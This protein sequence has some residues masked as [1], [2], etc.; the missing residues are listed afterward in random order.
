MSP[1]RQGRASPERK[2]SL[3]SILYYTCNW[4]VNTRNVPKTAD[5]IV[6]LPVISNLKVDVVNVSFAANTPIHRAANVATVAAKGLVVPP[7]L[8]S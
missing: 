1:S 8:V 7:H 2:A 3:F 6:G 4:K 5:I